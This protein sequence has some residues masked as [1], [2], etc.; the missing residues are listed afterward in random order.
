[1]FYLSRGL[2]TLSMIQWFYCFIHFLIFPDISGV[3]QYHIIACLGGVLRFDI[4][5]YY[6]MDV[7]LTKYMQW[8]R[9]FSAR[10]QY[11]FR[12]FMHNVI[13]YCIRV[14]SFVWL[15]NLV[16]ILCKYY[17]PNYFTLLTQSNASRLFICL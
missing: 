13:L 4:L 12:S 16:F 3:T 6:I 2:C 7:L 10:F 11:N 15:N 17:F 9:H 8:F 14:F 1:M 5:K